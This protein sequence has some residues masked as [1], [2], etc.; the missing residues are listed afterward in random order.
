VDF[1]D[2]QAYAQA[3]GTVLVVE[4]AAYHAPNF[5]SREADYGA[6]VA[7]LLRLGASITAVDYAQAMHTLQQARGGAADTVLDGVD[8]LA[9]PTCPVPAP[10]IASAR[11]QD[12]TL[13]LVALTGVFDLTGQP[14]ISVPCGLT[15]GGLPVGISFA[16]RRWDEA[17]VLW[18]GRAYEQ[19]RG[20]FPTP[21]LV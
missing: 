12:P 9:T 21:P 16:G 1:S 18:A 17:S 13:R 15:A 4:A 3:N 11:E 8:V 20:A 5:P 6:Q 19:V 7:S 10:T 14:V 2:A